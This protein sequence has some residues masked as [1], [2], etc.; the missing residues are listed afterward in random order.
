MN[1]KTME[2]LVGARTN[3][4]LLNTP[5]RVYKEA[6]LKGDTETMER[7]IGY[8]NEFSGKAEEYKSEADKG[9]EEDA[10]QAR[11]KAK[12]QREEAIPKR[13]EEREKLEERTGENRNADS[14]A[15]IRE[16]K[17]CILEI[18]EEG[19]ALLKDNTNSDS[20]GTDEIKLDAVITNNS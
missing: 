12:L 16:T 6:R 20:T 3:M 11:E 7:S 17:A 5:M 4:N 14:N 1:A 8:V 15:D 18:S 10:R 2:G 9:M 19:K 13:R